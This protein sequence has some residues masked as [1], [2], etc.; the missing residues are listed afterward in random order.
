MNYLTEGIKKCTR[1][2]V[3]KILLGAV[4]FSKFTAA[5]G[6]QLLE[7]FDEDLLDCYNREDMENVEVLDLPLS[8][9]SKNK[10]VPLICEGN[11]SAWSNTWRWPRSKLDFS[12]NGR[13]LKEE[14]NSESN[15]NMAG[16]DST[17]ETT[18]QGNGKSSAKAGSNENGRTN[19]NAQ[20]RTGRVI[21]EKDSLRKYSKKP[22]INGNS[23]KRTDRSLCRNMGKRNF[24]IDVLKSLLA[25]LQPNHVNL[26]SW[27]HIVS[28]IMGSL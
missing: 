18:D 17:G 5:E 9:S 24:D 28:I 25:C 1:C 12:S 16:A 6:K 11:T 7:D 4:L 19:G 27:V 2:S 15:F 14:D 21:F 23:S 13:H 3:E 10:N 8:D 22:F 26:L 20:A